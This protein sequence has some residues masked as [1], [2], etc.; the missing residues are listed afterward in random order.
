MSALL[1][2]SGR[3]P[4]VFGKPFKRRRRPF[5]DSDEGVPLW[6]ARLRMNAPSR[7]ET[8]ISAKDRRTASSDQGS[9]RAIEAIHPSIASRQ[10]V[11]ARSTDLSNRGTT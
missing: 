7:L 1:R 11:L 5:S 2:T 6:R 3:S 10:R 9:S 4:G 8:T